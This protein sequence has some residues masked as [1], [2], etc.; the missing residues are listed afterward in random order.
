MA[1]PQSTR[2][3]EISLE[4]KDKDI[5]DYHPICKSPKNG[6]QTLPSDN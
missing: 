6:F 4:A 1:F 5:K 3:W 2:W